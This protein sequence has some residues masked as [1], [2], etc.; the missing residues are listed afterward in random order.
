MRESIIRQIE[1]EKI[2]AI[3]R[4]VP[5]IKLLPFC[6]AVLSGGI[7]MLE[8]AY[9]S[10]GAQ[11]EETASQICMLSEQFGNDLTLGAGTV[12]TA[13]QVQLTKEAGGK[14][15]ISPNVDPTVIRATLEVGL[16]SIPG[17]FTPTEIVEADYFGADFVKLFPASVL[18]PAYAKAILSP[19]AHIRLLAVGGINA[20]NIPDYLKCGIRGF[21]IGSDLTKKDV[22][23]D[24]AKITKLARRY[25]E[26]VGRAGEK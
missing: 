9:P 8:I 23:D 12:L 17:A 14:F 10:S 18:G 6:E 15:I 26:A 7:R 24:P 13:E 2:I 25:V 20:E 5:T 3:V 4:G 19:L 22:L 21:G 16:V 1:S 11:N